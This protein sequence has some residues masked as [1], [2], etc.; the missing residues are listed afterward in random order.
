MGRVDKKRRLIS[1]W[2]PHD[3]KLVVEGIE[4]ALDGATDSS[5]LPGTE[6]PL[7]MSRPA[8]EVIGPARLLPM[9]RC[10]RE[11]RDPRKAF[12]VLLVL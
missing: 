1:I 12:M 11:P 2:P 3:V 6:R 9:P 10:M 4:N 5:L 7:K 8:K